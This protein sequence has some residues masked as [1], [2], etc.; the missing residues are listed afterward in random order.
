MKLDMH[1]HS[2]ASDGQYSPEKLVSM[3]HELDLEFF[4]ITDHDSISGLEAACYEAKIKGIRFVPGIEISAQE[5]EEIHV[6]G[7]GIDY[8]NPLIIKA[9]E[10]YAFDRDNRAE[11]ICEYL[12][13]KGIAVSMKEIHEIAGDSVIGRPHFAT[14]LL[15]EGYVKERKEAFDLYLDTSEFADATGRKEPTVEDAISI[16]HSV[17]GKAVLAHPGFIKKDTECL[18][19]FIKK[20]KDAGLDGIE[21]FYSQHS[22]EKTKLYLSYASKY[23]LKISAG[24][25]F[26]GE[27]V[28]SHVKLGMEIDE[29]EVGDRFVIDLN[30]EF[31]HD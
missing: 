6:L 15:R 24:S 11:R 7:Y 23:D 5:N 4:S 26:H 25:D 10:K 17:G 21:C 27:K 28:K 22:A 8:K 31:I 12:G 30:W 13:S 16:I 9:C 14:Y 3:A 20:A 19:L 1:T 18:E 2:T 29:K